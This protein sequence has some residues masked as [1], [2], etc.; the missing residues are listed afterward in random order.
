MGV[1][2]DAG[3]P[4][5]AVPGRSGCCAFKN[6]DWDLALDGRLDRRW[7]QDLGSKVS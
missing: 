4:V 1:V 5:M 2:R 3:A 6:P 7:V